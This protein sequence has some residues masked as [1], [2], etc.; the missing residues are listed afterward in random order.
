LTR[1]Q[2][3][4]FNPNKSGIVTQG[5]DDGND[6]SGLSQQPTTM[7]V[8]TWIDAMVSE[9]DQ[10]SK[11]HQCSLLSSLLLYKFDK[12]GPTMAM[13]RMVMAILS[14]ISNGFGSY[15]TSS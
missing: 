3:I 9:R 11:F 1:Q 7:K 6:H 8:M 14:Q 13:V 4:I 10:P 2:S 15:L 12:N 5:D